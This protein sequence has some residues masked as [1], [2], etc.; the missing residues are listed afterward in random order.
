VRHILWFSGLAVLL[1]I[2]GGCGPELSRTDLGTVEFKLPDPKVI[3]A[4]KPYPM[5]KLATPDE[6]KGLEGLRTPLS[7]Q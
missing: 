7:D 2:F 6:K 3:G 5:P 4:D 1:V